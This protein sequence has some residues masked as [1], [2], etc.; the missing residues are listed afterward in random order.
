MGEPALWHGLRVVP[1]T[2]SPV[3]YDPKTGEVA[4]AEVMTVLGTNCYIDPKTA[5]ARVRAELA[6]VD[7]DKDP[8]S[9]TR[10]SRRWLG[11]AVLGAGGRANVVEDIARQVLTREKAPPRLSQGRQRPRRE[12]GA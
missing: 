5:F 9:A 2:F 10:R 4:I 6:R 1:V 3:T 8:P 12:R 11:A 7:H